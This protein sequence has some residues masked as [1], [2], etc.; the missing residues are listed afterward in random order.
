MV[1][2]PLSVPL[3]KC[4]PIF[5]DDPQIK[6]AIE[7]IDHQISKS[8][9]EKMDR[10]ARKMDMALEGT[11]VDNALLEHRLTGEDCIGVDNL[12]P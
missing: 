6:E 5:I 12:G 4:S 2:F 3:M 8:V 7:Y 9:A 10:V 11:V 1:N